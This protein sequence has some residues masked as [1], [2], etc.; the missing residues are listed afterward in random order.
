MDSEK[1]V[2]SIEIKKKISHMVIYETL[3]LA[4]G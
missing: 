3:F 4:I 1:S 2:Y